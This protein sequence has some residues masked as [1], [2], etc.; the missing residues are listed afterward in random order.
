[1][2]THYDRLRLLDALEKTNIEATLNQHIKI[3]DLIKNEDKNNVDSL[4]EKHLLN[5]KDVIKKYEAK[6]PEYFCSK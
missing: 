4:V 1:M 3:V 5:Y 6:Y 2:S